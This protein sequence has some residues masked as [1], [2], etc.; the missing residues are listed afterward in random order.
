MVAKTHTCETF[1]SILA[2]YRCLLPDNSRRYCFTWISL[3]MILWGPAYGQTPFFMSHAFEKISDANLSVMGQDS[4][5]FLW[6]GCENGLYRFDGIN[7][8]LFSTSDTSGLEHVTAIYCSGKKI[9]LGYNSGRIYYLNQNKKLIA[10]LPEEGVPEVPITGIT[11]DGNGR[12]WFSTYGEGA[13]VYDGDHLYNFNTDDG[14]LENQI[15]AL[16][17]DKEGAVWLATDNGL[18]ICQFVDKRK[19]IHN[20]TKEHGLLDEIVYVLTADETGMWMGFHRGGFC[21]YSLELDTIDYLTRT[22][23][24]GSIRS[25]CIAGLSI[26]VGTEDQG[27]FKCKIGTSSDI[28]W[29]DPVPEFLQKECHEILYDR[30]GNLWLFIDHNQIYSGHS[31]VQ[32]LSHRL[33]DVQAICED[34]AQRVWIGSQHGLYQLEGGKLLD[35]RWK[36]ENIISLYHDNQGKIWIGTFGDGVICWNPQTNQSVRLTESDG[37]MNGSVFSIDGYQDRLWLATLGGI[38]EIYNDD[39]IF[40]SKTIRYLNLHPS[41]GLY[42]NFFYKVFV[43]R[44]GVVWFGTDGQGV[45]KLENEIASNLLTT[46]HLPVRTAYSITQDYHGNI[47]FSTNNDGVY[48]FDGDTFLH[49]GLEKGLRNLSITS[50][51]MD[52]AGGIIMVHEAGFDIFDLHSRTIRYFDENVGV[53]HLAPSLNAVAAGNSKSVWIGGNNKLVRYLFDENIKQ[54]YPNLVFDEIRLFNEAIDYA[55]VQTFSHRE[56]FIQ[57]EYIGLW[58]TDPQEISYQYQLMGYDRDWRESRD[59]LISYPKLT[60]G[61]YN[62]RVRSVI[63]DQVV[64]PSEISY[65]FQINRPF[66]NRAWFLILFSLTIGS[67]IYAYQRNRELRISRAAAL[68]RERIESQYE[69]LKAQINPHFLFNSF[70]T[71]ANIVEEDTDLAVEYIEKLSDYYRSIIQFRNQKMIL[72]EEELEMIDDFIYLLKKRFGKNLRVIK[73]IDD[74]EYYIPPLT[75]QMLVENAIKHNVISRQKPLTISIRSKNDDYLVVENNLQPKKTKEPS[76]KFGLQNINTRFELLTK[77][78]VLVEDKNGSFRV[79]IPLTKYNEW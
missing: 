1:Q 12:L 7:Y 36:D 30:E 49:Y 61:F 79:S 50:L 57:F 68:T 39:Q 2:A 34:Q 35:T 14:L 29:K 47:W 55:K 6:F 69:V 24:Y 43:D 76:T 52:E 42:A 26:F 4:N 67:L 74:S 60:P 54:T 5:G 11:E 3:V 19:I 44:D 66:W 41:D 62:F 70:N 38:V 78:K 64:E 48:S 58:H 22:W 8:D 17:T 71:L 37:M 28:I 9:W 10:W 75:L 32:V 65:P 31:N 51:A 16:A 53:G 73:K 23:E 27:V 33:G 63:N 21:H 20:L 77:R 45:I 15:Y 18:S 56:N 46:G 59:Q 25:L 40:R 72:L 13:Y